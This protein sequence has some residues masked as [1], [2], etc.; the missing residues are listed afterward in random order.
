MKFYNPEYTAVTTEDIIGGECSNSE[1]TAYADLTDDEIQLIH[2]GLLLDGTYQQWQ[3]VFIKNDSTTDTLTGVAVYGYNKNS[4]GIVEFAIE[5]DDDSAIVKDGDERIKNM[6]TEPD[7]HGTYTYYD[8]RAIFAISLPDLAPLESVGIW[9]KCEFSAI[10]AYADDDEFVLG[11]LYDT[12]EQ[13]EITL[14]HRRIDTEVDI[15]K[16]SIDYAN[17]RGLN[18]EYA[19]VDT[20]VVGVDKHD[21]VYA[22]YVDK[23]FV[24][25]SI[26]TG[27]IQLQL[28]GD[29]IPVLIE[30]YLILYSG[31]RPDVGEVPTI[32]KN[33]L[34][35]T[36][37]SKRFSLEDITRFYIYWDNKTGS[38]IA[39]A[40]AEIDAETGIGGGLSVEQ[41]SITGVLNYG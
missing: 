27:R 41:T 8:V 3:K 17:P 40:F 21:A 15:I 26:G 23:M 7:L 34:K 16:T 25:E 20:S 32:R 38:Y 14:R 18:V 30:V 10:D 37:S 24:K 35:F 39:S 2:T 12:L 22:V 11:A 5:I 4:N 13:T 28:Y 6:F 19:M 31:Y 33:R 29:N 36:W 1:I 9:L